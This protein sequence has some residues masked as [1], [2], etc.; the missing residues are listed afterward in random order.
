MDEGDEDISLQCLLN[1]LM[2]NKIANQNDS[3][4]LNIQSGTK[5]EDN[6]TEFIIIRAYTRFFLVDIGADLGV[7]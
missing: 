1:Y 5:S 3:C 6:M 4:T 2:S 7:S